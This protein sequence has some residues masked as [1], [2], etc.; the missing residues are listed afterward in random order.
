[1]MQIVR[2]RTRYDNHDK[3]TKLYAVFRRL[4]GNFKELT[5]L[6]G[7]NELCSVFSALSYICNW[8]NCSYYD[9]LQTVHVE[10]FT[11]TP[12]LKPRVTRHE[13]LNYSLYL[14]CIW[15]M[16]AFVNGFCRCLKL[17][18]IVCFGSGLVVRSDSV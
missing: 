15:L 10:L 14:R 6:Q 3:S 17:F 13:R 16:F 4:L 11:I 5:A 8:A 7:R 1:M 18:N 9:S 12:G 2:W